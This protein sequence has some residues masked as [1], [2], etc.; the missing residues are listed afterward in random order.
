MGQPCCGRASY[1]CISAYSSTFLV[2]IYYIVAPL[3]SG[4]L[5][6]F[7]H[8]S[9]IH[10]DLMYSCMCICAKC[11]R[12]IYQPNYLLQLQTSLQVSIIYIKCGV[13][14]YCKQIGIVHACVCFC[15]IRQTN[16]NSKH[17]LHDANPPPITDH[18]IVP[19]RVVQ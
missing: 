3:F 5:H 7:V 8:K 13:D 17:T 11:I 1:V 9:S 12:D 14:L 2:C 6:P 10:I 16:T 15:M 19:C 4:C 18:S